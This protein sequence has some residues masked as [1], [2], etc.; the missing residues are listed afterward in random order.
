MLLMMLAK[1]NVFFPS[2]DLKKRNCLSK[3]VKKGVLGDLKKQALI[4]TG[5]RS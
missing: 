5:G 4:S 3:D 2:N 1:V